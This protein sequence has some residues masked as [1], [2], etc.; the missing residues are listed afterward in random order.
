MPCLARSAGGRQA[1]GYEFPGCFSCLPPPPL[2]AS[3]GCRGGG[4]TL[5]VPSALGTG[6]EAAC[7]VVVVLSEALPGS[8]PPLERINL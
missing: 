8:L 6:E 4:G 1:F 7:L 3:V 5:P 2:Q